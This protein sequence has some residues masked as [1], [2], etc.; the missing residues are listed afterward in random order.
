MDGKPEGAGVSIVNPDNGATITVTAQLFNVSG[1]LFDGTNI[2]VTDRGDNTLKRLDVNG[3]VIQFIH[4]GAE[5][6]IP[7]FDGSNI[8]VPNF[9]SNTVT[10]VRAR[11]LQ[12]LAVLSGNG[13]NHPF[14]A[15]FDGQRSL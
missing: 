15:A 11:D 9:T 13:L 4:V 6:D 1:I 3:T 8:W 5:P 7:V 10:V 14:Q 12:Q 2:F